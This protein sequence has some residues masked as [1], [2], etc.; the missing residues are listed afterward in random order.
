MAARIPKGQPLIRKKAC[1]SPLQEMIF[2]VETISMQSRKKLSREIRKQSSRS[3][4]MHEDAT[5]IL[6]SREEV[7][8]SFIRSLLPSEYPVQYLVFFMAFRRDFVRVKLKMCLTRMVLS[9]D[10]LTP[11]LFSLW[12]NSTSSRIGMKSS[13]NPPLFSKTL[14]PMT[15]AWLAI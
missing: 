6:S 4:D 7:P 12:L 9:I 5:L 10:S 14:L 13:A 3:Q 8:E 15:M 2:S 1:M 11:A